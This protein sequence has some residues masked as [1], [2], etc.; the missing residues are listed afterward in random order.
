[1]KKRV[2]QLAK[3]GLKVENHSKQASKAKK[4]LA[5]TRAKQQMLC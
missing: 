3:A 4:A 2:F 5:A 1:M